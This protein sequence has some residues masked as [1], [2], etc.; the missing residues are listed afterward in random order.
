MNSNKKKQ[1]LATFFSRCSR[2]IY[3]HGSFTCTWN[4]LPFRAHEFNPDFYWVR[5][6]RSLVLCVYFVDRF[7][8]F[9]TFTFGHCV[10]CSSS[11]YRFWLP[12][13]YLQ[14]LLTDIV[15]WFKYEYSGIIQQI[16]DIDTLRHFHSKIYDQLIFSFL[17]S[18]GNPCLYFCTFSI[19]HCIV[20]T[21]TD[22][23][24]E[25]KVWIYQK[26]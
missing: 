2:K 19:G 11:M 21:T 18:L 9:C 12:L 20:C 6:T 25:I 16:L 3:V 13:W 14:T 10:V 5:V 26:P 15:Y 8:S 17:C 4:C 23:R 1:W 24:Q 22:Y 7:L